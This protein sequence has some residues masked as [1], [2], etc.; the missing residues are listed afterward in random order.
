MSP[1]SPEP[2]EASVEAVRLGNGH[3]AVRMTLGP[4]DIHVLT[5]GS[6]DD[7]AAALVQAAR[8]CRAADS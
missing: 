1:S 2:F 7:L 6:A 4:V 3:S 5:P 8:V